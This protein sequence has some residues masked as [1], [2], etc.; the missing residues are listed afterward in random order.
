[1]L[2]SDDDLIALIEP[3]AEQYA[4]VATNL[5]GQTYRF[6]AIFDRPRHEFQEMLSGSNPSLLCVSTDVAH[7]NQA[8]GVEINSERWQVRDMQPDGK[9]LT[10][11]EIKK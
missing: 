5:S 11:I 7:I 3:F 9:G 1:M 8:D 2:F 6:M 10:R 4:V